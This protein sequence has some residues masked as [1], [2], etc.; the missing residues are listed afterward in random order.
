MEPT[1]REIRPKVDATIKIHIFIE[2]LQKL[3]ACF[4]TPTAVSLYYH[5]LLCLFLLLNILVLRNSFDVEFVKG[6]VSEVNSYAGSSRL[7]C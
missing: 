5:F 7:S 2:L 3:L 4:R 6:H 1:C